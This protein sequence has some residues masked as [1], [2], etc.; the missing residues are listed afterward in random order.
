MLD[1]C[2]RVDSIVDF[3]T[4]PHCF[5]IHGDRA[6]EAHGV[7]KLQ[8]EIMSQA[9][10][11]SRST[12][13][14]HEAGRARNHESHRVP[15]RTMPRETRAV[16]SVT[17]PISTPGAAQPP[18]RHLHRAENPD[19]YFNEVAFD[20][21]TPTDVPAPEPKVIQ[22]LALYAFEALE[23]VRSIAQLG[24][25]VTPAVTTALVSRRAARTERR[26]LYS[27]NRRVVATPGPVHIDRPLPHVIEAA[28]VLH[29]VP[30]TLPVAMRL[31][32]R[33]RQWQI[34]EL[35]VM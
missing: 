27:D 15:S 1:A 10:R 16:A 21:S 4:T 5:K 33:N 14:I 34:T 35:V 28:L 2:K 23:G 30:R 19:L 31:E 24:S 7:L 29:A 26:T 25:W 12:R 18:P 3:H 32:F 9:L 11:T 22:K 20:T 6:E 13:P 8:G 17:A